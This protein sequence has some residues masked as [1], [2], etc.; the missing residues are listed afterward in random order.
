MGVKL[1]IFDFWGTLVNTGTWSPLRQSQQIL[2]V[3]APFSGFVQHFERT[4]MTKSFPDMTSAFTSICQAFDKRPF[5]VVIE[6]LI[7]IWTKN[8]ELAKPFI[9]TA[10]TLELLSKKYKLALLTNSECFGTEGLLVKHDIA[11]YFSAM[12]FSHK[13]GML[14]SDPGTVASLLNELKV[15]PA[16][17]VIVGDSVESD[18]AAASGA[19]VRGIL[20]DRSDRREYTPK[21]ISLTELPAL[22]EQP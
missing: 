17:A 11:K 10:E 2:R 9:D 16:D 18:M 3:H 4:F 13:A 1:I 20:I 14:K 22:L 8:T 15:A 6:K 19:G 7:E 21:I 5:P 12:H